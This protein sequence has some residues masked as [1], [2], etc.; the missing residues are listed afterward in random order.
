MEE[1]ENCL[2]CI[3]RNSYPDKENMIYCRLLKWNVYALALPCKHYEKFDGY[4]KPF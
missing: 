3:W 2:N 4:N 1:K